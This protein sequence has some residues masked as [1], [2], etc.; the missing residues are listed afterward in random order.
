MT[1]EGS[2]TVGDEAA[3]V[4]ADDAVPGRS[5]ALVERPLDVLCDILLPVSI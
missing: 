5:L 1:K 4:P 3:K 2:H